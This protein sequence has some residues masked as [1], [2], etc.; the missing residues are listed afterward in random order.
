MRNLLTFG[1]MVT[2]LSAAGVVYVR[3]QHRVVF[4]ELQQ[5]LAERDRLNAE[6]SQL[7]LEQSTWSFHHMVEK[8][9]RRRL[10]MVVPEPGQIRVLSIR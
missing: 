9:A 3:H 2:V 10:S 4:V 7:L 8:N 6:W 5:A 1:L